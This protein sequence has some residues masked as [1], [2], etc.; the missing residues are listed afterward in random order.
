MVDYV[1][2]PENPALAIAKLA[3][4]QTKIVSLT[5]TEGGYNFDQNGDF[6]FDNPDI[7]WDIHHPEAPKTVFGL[8]ARALKM[9]YLN[10][11]EPFTVLSC[12]NIQHN[13]DVVR[14]MLL[15]FTK[16]VDKSL[17]EWIRTNA[18]F[19]NSMVDRIT[20]VTMPQDI[21]LLR[22][23]TGIEDDCPV[24]CE[25]F[26]QW[27]LEDRFPTGRPVWEKVG[28]QFVKDIDPYEKMKLRLL[29][30]GHSFLGFVGSLFSY[31]TIDETINNPLICKCLRAF[32]DNEVT[33]LLG[34]I[35]GVD[36][37]DYK[38]NL[39][40][41]FRNPNIRDQLTRICSESSVKLPKFL[42]PTV[43]EQL[44]RNGP[45]RYAIIALAAWFR[46][47]ELY[48]V[49]KYDYP[50]QDAMLDELTQAATDDTPLTFLRLESVFGDLAQN[51][52]FIGE[53]TDTFNNIRE[54]GIEKTLTNLR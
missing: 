33:P 2:V 30:A 41:R 17:A 28:A 36:L 6:I 49:G 31:Q 16:R 34:H 29:N 46:T 35:E 21:E 14:K 26:V 39:I 50:I 32:M 45:V 4:A 27:V 20:P 44:E 19:P 1:F 10:G 8:L 23:K 7:Q 13:G 24:T 12:D 5:I 25:P 54:Y 42:I 48:A 38:D 18:S 40:E 43:N 52:R 53:F 15:S 47:L 22:E 3:D 37:E 9:R 11:Y 51:P